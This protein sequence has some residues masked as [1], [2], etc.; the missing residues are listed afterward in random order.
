MGL[1]GWERHTCRGMFGRVGVE[2]I[3]GRGRAEAVRSREAILPCTKK[4]EVT[5]GG[6][7]GGV[8]GRILLVAK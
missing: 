5:M 8:N 6:V 2:R 3:E 4:R 7:R 1:A